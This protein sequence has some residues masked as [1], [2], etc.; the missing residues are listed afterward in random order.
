MKNL[1]E[2]WCQDSGLWEV[3]GV[4]HDIDW[5]E[6]R[7]KKEMHGVIAAEQLRDKVPDA[8]LDAIKC[9]D[10]RTGFV[11]LSKLDKALIFADGLA[12]IFSGMDDVSVF[13][14]DLFLDRLELVS[15]KGRPWMKD[16]VL[17]Y[18]EDNDLSV[19]FMNRLWGKIFT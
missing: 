16:I 9:H 2:Y 10:H 19:E 15:A 4:L 18:I 6:T 11:P 8:G 3:V 12:H 13:R 7:D 1:A 17:R 5:D 14:Y